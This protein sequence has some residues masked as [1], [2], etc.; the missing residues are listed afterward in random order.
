MSRSSQGNSKWTDNNAWSV[1]N[2]YPGQGGGDTGT[3]AGYNLNYDFTGGSTPG[4]QL[5]AGAT[6]NT[7]SGSK[8]A[9]ATVTGSTLNINNPTTAN[10]LNVGGSSTFAIIEKL[11]ITTTLTVSSSTFSIDSTSTSSNPLAISIGGKA[12]IASLISANCGGNDI[13]M[14]VGNFNTFNGLTLTGNTG[15]VF[16]LPYYSLATA[17]SVTSA[18][19]NFGSAITYSG[20]VTFSVAGTGGKIVTPSISMSSGS[21]IVVTSTASI[22]SGTSNTPV[23]IH[24]DT[25]T[26]SIQSPTAM[27]FDPSSYTQAAYIQINDPGAQV[28]FVDVNPGSP[29]TMNM[30]TT[31]WDF[32]QCASSTGVI[33]KKD[34]TISQLVNI[35]NS[36]NLEVQGRTTTIL[37]GTLSIAN[38]AL[39]SISGGTVTLASGGTI[40]GTP[41]AG[42]RI[43]ITGGTFNI[44]GVIN[45]N[46]DFAMNGGTTNIG[47]NVDFSTTNVIQTTGNLAITSGATATFSA[48]TYNYNGATGSIS[49]PGT[50]AVSTTGTIQFNAAATVNSGLTISGGNL[51]FVQSTGVVTVAGSFTSS[52]GTITATGA[53]T[54]SGTTFTYSGGTMTGGTVTISAATA[55]ITG[56]SITTSGAGTTLTISST[57]TISSPATFTATN[58]TIVISSPLTITGT[59]SFIGATSTQLTASATVTNF[60]TLT[61]GGGNPATISGPITVTTSANLKLSGT[62]SISSTVS[63]TSANIIILSGATAT[64]TGGGITTSAGSVLVNGNLVFTSSS[65]MSIDAGV[66][67]TVPTGA[68][69]SFQGSSKI[70]EGGTATMNQFSLNGGTLDYKSSVS[71]TLDSKLKIVG[72]TSCTVT[73]GSTLLTLTAGAGILDL[74]TCSFSAQGSLTVN[75]ATTFKVV[76]GQCSISSGLILSSANTMELAGTT[77]TQ[78]GLTLNGNSKLS[79]VFPTGILDSHVAGG[80][81]TMNSFSSMYASG[82]TLYLDSS[83]NMNNNASINVVNTGSLFLNGGTVTLHD[84]AAINVTSGFFDTTS[85]TANFYDSSQL[86]L[87][88]SS[89]TVGNGDLWFYQDSLLSFKSSS[90]VGKLP[91]GTG[92]IHIRKNATILVEDSTVDFQD[93]NIFDI[94]SGVTITLTGNVTVNGITT[95]AAGYCVVYFGL[96]TNIDIVNKGGINIIQDGCVELFFYANLAITDGFLSIDDRGSFYNDFYATLSLDATSSLT[97]QKNGTFTSDFYSDIYANGAVTINGDGFVDNLYLDSYSYLSIGGNFLIQS[98]SKALFS[99]STVDVNSNSFNILGTASVQFVA[100]SVLNLNGGVCN[101]QAKLYLSQSMINLASSSKINVLGTNSNFTVDSSTLYLNGNLTIDT[102][103]KFYA[104]SSNLYFNNNFWNI[105]S[106]GY[107]SVSGSGYSASLQNAVINLSSG[108]LDI[109]NSYVVNS[110]TASSGFSMSGAAIV[111]LFSSSSISM[112]YGSFNMGGTSQLNINPTTQV[113]FLSTSNGLTTTGTS[114]VN[115]A[116]GLL[117]ISHT[118]TLTGL[119]MSVNSAGTVT[120]NSGAPVIFNGAAGSGLTVTGTGSQYNSNDLLSFQSFSTSFIRAGLKVY[121]LQLTDNSTFSI[122]SGAILTFTLP[123]GLSIDKGANLVIDHTSFTPSGTLQVKNFAAVTLISGSLYVTNTFTL[124][125]YSKII[126]QTGSLVD[127]AGASFIITDTSVSSTFTG[128]TLNVHTGSFFYGKLNSNVNFQSTQLNLDGS[129]TMQDSAASQFSSAV[130]VINSGGSFILTGSSSTTFGTSTSVTGTTAT[131]TFIMQQNAVLT[132]TNSPITLRSAS[133]INYAK[134]LLGSSTMTISNS[135][136]IANNANVTL[137]GQTV[138]LGSGTTSSFSDDALLQ[139]FST[140]VVAITSATATLNNN[141]DIKISAVN[142]KLQVTTSTFTLRNYAKVEA[143][144][145]GSAVF[146]GPGQLIGHD[147]SKLYF[148]TTTSFISNNNDILLYEFAQILFDNT[149]VIHISGVVNLYNNSTMVIQNNANIDISGSMTLHDSSVFSLTACTFSPTSAAIVV[150]DYASVV[151]YQSDL[152]LN[153]GSLTFKNYAVLELLDSTSNI[154]ITAGDLIFQDNAMLYVP[155]F[156]NITISGNLYFGGSVNITWDQLYV[157]IKGSLTLQNSAN[158]FIQS[159]VFD[160]HGTVNSIDDSSLYITDSEITIINP[161]SGFIATGSAL[162]SY[163][164]KNSSLDIFGD[165]SFTGASTQL[166]D[167]RSR[168]T[169]DDGNLLLSGTVDTTFTGNTAF[170]ITG[171]SANFDQQSHTHFS[172]ASFATHGGSVYFQD[173]SFVDFVNTP[174]NVAFGNIYFVNDTTFTFDSANIKVTSGSMFFDN[175]SDSTFNNFNL[176]ISGGALN[177]NIQFAGNSNADFKTGNITL[178]SGNVE[179]TGSSTPSF[180]QINLILT[181]GSFNF[182]SATVSD[183]TNSKVVIDVGSFITTG[184]SIV[185]FVNTPLTITTSVGGEL[186]VTN[187]SQVSFT[188]SPISV[189]GGDVTVSNTAKFSILDAFSPLLINGGNFVLEN[190]AVYSGYWYSNLHS[191]W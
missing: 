4:V 134:A 161:N 53:V 147:N 104:Y 23:V 98:A 8:M 148:P 188:T 81:V 160:L 183:F 66:T 79:F 16:T 185:T 62:V 40:S 71:L 117:T 49:G 9:D 138:N 72:T 36:C 108:T 52:G 5:T 85:G 14:S 133:F 125:D 29:S 110:L 12:D 178:T 184:G 171:G 86:V 20:A 31:K 10:S 129:F 44:N 152:N 11:T 114:L 68:K 155:Q 173:T 122:Q 88:S 7:Q 27:L 30:G 124:N 169:I 91:G 139:I 63:E 3:V 87:E 120:Q 43:K 167:Q 22:Y 19:L 25:S 13:T 163:I 37:T 95:Y 180:S 141:F 132:S 151:L 74:N 115:V 144:S 112:Q 116:G 135:L 65:Q 83:I 46:S 102:N 126:S 174:M 99:L 94:E 103:G 82:R 2:T 84:G 17:M 6:L 100:S 159:T 64:F 166:F 145:S 170:D 47:A 154:I 190:N 177:L 56:G 93:T 42:T 179:F 157:D 70:I 158:L 187:T 107:A 26:L 58:P 45:I 32:T 38:T 175:Y 130:I 77:L 172:Q 97:I 106:T 21:Q 150:Q 191:Q 96:F 50:L 146:T 143:S 90:T 118:S 123:N 15:C 61:I 75:D 162:S 164:F 18:T 189:F 127:I 28:T 55:S 137:T 76:N 153:G 24:Q 48:S 78:S 89:L 111:N 149:L 165:A 128:S 182:D 181:D 80:L 57:A 59:A 176:N 34:W 121:S 92:K 142:S 105:F 156:G 54:F 131:S 39:F 67:I 109:T 168:I 186:L 101:I 51:K 35:A 113:N 69:V 60:G 33:A 136:Q 140:S 1:A 41:N 119:G 73:I